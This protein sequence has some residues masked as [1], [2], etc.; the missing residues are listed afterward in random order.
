MRPTHLDQRA[1]RFSALTQRSKLCERALNH[2]T[3]QAVSEKALCFS[4]KQQRDTRSV[5]KLWREESLRGSGVE[6]LGQR[7]REA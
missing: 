2:S 5:L 7:R 6:A 3:L 4:L 1:R